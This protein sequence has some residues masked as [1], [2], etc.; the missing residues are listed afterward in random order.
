MRK[1]IPRNAD[2]W[3]FVICMLTIPALI[4]LTIY[5]STL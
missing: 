5:V 4:L 3:D 2:Q 1:F